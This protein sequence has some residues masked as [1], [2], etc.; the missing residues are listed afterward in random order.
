[1]YVLP[2][3]RASNPAREQSNT[4]DALAFK[5]LGAELEFSLFGTH[6][7]SVAQ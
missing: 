7:A 2:A 5:L 4:A 6:V 3:E 1:V